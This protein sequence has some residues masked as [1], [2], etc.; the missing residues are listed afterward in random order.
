MRVT[1]SSSEVDLGSHPLARKRDGMPGFEAT[2]EDEAVA[3][4]EDALV[5]EAGPKGEKKGRGVAFEDEEIAVAEDALVEEDEVPVAMEDRAGRGRQG[6][7]AGGP[8]P[9]PKDGRRWFGGMLLGLPLV[10]G[11]GAGAY[12]GAP[13][14]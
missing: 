14:V 2:V 13:G 1:D 5:D 4:A 10:G 7:G 12:H 6:G 9:K 8:P 3:E 11:A